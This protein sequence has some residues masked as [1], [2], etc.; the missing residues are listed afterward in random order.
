[1]G[2][3]RIHGLIVAGI[4][5]ASQAAMVKSLLITRPVNHIPVKGP[6]PE[7]FFYAETSGRADKCHLL[8]PGNSLPHSTYVVRCHW[9]RDTTALPNAKRGYYLG[10]KR[11][12]SKILNAYS[13]SD[14]I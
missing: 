11:D 8:L 1:M 10:G 4:P 12:M 7:W 14:F 2:M 5:S 13:R 9:N 3:R 6:G